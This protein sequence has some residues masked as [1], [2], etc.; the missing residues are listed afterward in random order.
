M[1]DTKAQSEG[2]DSATN[3]V[4]EAKN[5]DDDDDD[6]D[7]YEEEHED[8]HGSKVVATLC[9]KEPK[10]K[11]GL[12]IAVVVSS[13]GNRHD[14]RACAEAHMEKLKKAAQHGDT[15]K[16]ITC[17]MI[18]KMNQKESKD[19]KENSE[20]AGDPENEKDAITAD[21]TENED[22]NKNEE[23]KD[24]DGDKDLE[25]G[26][27]HEETKIPYD[28]SE[29]MKSVYK[30]S[31]NYPLYGGGK[32]SK[33]I[34]VQYLKENADGLKKLTG[35]KTWII[36]HKSVTSHEATAIDDYF[37]DRKAGY[38]TVVVVLSAFFLLPKPKS[39]TQVQDQ[40]KKSNRYK[41]DSRILV[42]SIPDPDKGKADDPGY[43]EDTFSRVKA[44]I[45]RYN[46]KVVS[47]QK[48]IPEIERIAIS[49][50]PALHKKLLDSKPKKKKVG[51]KKA[52]SSD[53]TK[54]KKNL[55]KKATEKSAGK[56]S[57]QKAAIT[58]LDE[59]D[60]KSDDGSEDGSDTYS[61]NGMVDDDEDSVTNDVWFKALEKN[62]S[63]FRLI[64]MCT[65]HDPWQAPSNVKEYFKNSKT[66]TGKFPD[67]IDINNSSK[68][69]EE[70]EEDDEDEDGVEKIK[71]GD[72]PGTLFICDRQAGKR[73]GNEN[74][75][76][77]TGGAF[78][79]WVPMHYTAAMVKTD[80][81]DNASEINKLID[82]IYVN[83]KKK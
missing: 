74:D 70:D 64:L 1:S 83:K 59:P 2:D 47:E 72:V 8:D 80:Q 51:A 52:E 71:L 3:P 4:K 48:G 28:P 50:P 58:N 6:D 23:A 81:Y 75:S 66:V 10:D 19:R 82:V 21:D 18:A 15:S 46:Q 35:E 41:A 27:V 37:Y 20:P 42:C 17:G 67:C 55:S 78:G 43:Y 68:Q 77:T 79:S 12:V 39:T 32:P 38:K 57:T 40:S 30:T 7:D 31:E 22:E 61:V 63:A 53:K 11:K 60:D 54:T 33:K 13:K 62:L 65:N 44:F 24:G 14:A 56:A 16:V 73:V 5:D 25:T 36:P 9:R 49:Y 45:G 69:E 29:F 76:S 34:V 26:S